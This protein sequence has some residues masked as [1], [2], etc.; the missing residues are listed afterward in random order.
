MSRYPGPLPH[1]PQ[2]IP[3]EPLLNAHCTRLG[4][5]RRG[6]GDRGTGTGASYS[7]ATRLSL[8][9]VFGSC[10]KRGV[11]LD[12]FGALSVVTAC[13]TELMYVVVR[14]QRLRYGKRS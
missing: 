6:N 10:T 5:L 13:S 14:L 4:V 8:R 12:V 7:T 1:K 2:C 11:V 9:A 3:R